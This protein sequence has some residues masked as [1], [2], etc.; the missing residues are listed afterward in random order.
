MSAALG[1]GMCVMAL[2]I[3]DLG[4]DGWRVL[5]VLP[6]LAVPLLLAA[7]RLL[8]ESKRFVAPHGDAHVAGHGGRL[9][10]LALAAFF[11]QLFLTPVSQLQNEFLRDERSYSAAAITLF[12]IC[13]AT[14]AGLSVLAG[15]HLAEVRG[16]RVVGATGLVGGAVMLVAMYQT[17]GP[18]M[19]LFALLGAVFVG[20]TAP[21]LRVYG[22][23]LFPT[24]L[25]GGSGGLIAVAGVAGAAAGVLAA[26]FLSD[27]LG[28]LGRAILVL[29]AGPLLV[30]L[31]VLTKFPETAHRELEDLNPEDRRP[32]TTPS[33]PADRQHP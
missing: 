17:S 28:G 26:G 30:A 20:V 23:E 32:T 1:A 12:T 9:R 27:E 31:L 18:A 15:G 29:A 19:W 3:A 8:P 13:T 4:D 11:V 2:P 10:L 22:P 33:P 21:A 16:R 5:F 25:R 7:A 24:G 14:P 6:V